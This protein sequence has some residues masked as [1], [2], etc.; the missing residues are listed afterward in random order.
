[1][2]TLVIGQGAREH[3]LARA[4]KYSPNVREVHVLPGNDGMASLA[5]CHPVAQRD[6]SGILK[7]IESNKIELVVIGPDQALADGLADELRSKD[8]KVFG[9]SRECARLEWSKSFAKDFLVSAGVKTPRHF[10]VNNV[11]EVLDQAAA[12][13]PPYVLK[14]DGLALGKGVFICITDHDLYQAAD[15]VFHDKEF[16]LAGKS[17]ILEE[18]HEG[19]EL[20]AHILT[21]GRDFELFPFARDYK[22]LKDNDIGPNTGGMGAVAPVPV[23]DSLKEKIIKEVLKPVMKEMVRRKLEY[24][25]VLYV[26]IMETVSGE[27]QVLEFNA[28][29]GDPEAQV[30]LP[31]LKDQDW[32]SV[33]LKV[34][35]GKVPKLTWNDKSAA[36]VVLAAPGYPG[37]PEKNVL[38]RGNVFSESNNGYFLHAG[39]KHIC[40]EW[41]TF[42]GRVLNAVGIGANLSQAVQNAYRHAERVSWE[43]CQFRRDIGKG[44]G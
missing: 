4:L 9:P 41:R 15:T 25:G 30:F 7:I 18:F 38:I 27:I 42:G 1:M 20:S 28:R 2:N 33:F 6:V 10:V 26:G 23:T 39:A 17:A 3:A 32:A 12:F 16:A 14:A 31:L 11:K 13:S 40:G 24:R 34:A 37:N 8:V 5:H 21:N 44:I 22:R 35:D 19:K 29:F 43:G 36:C